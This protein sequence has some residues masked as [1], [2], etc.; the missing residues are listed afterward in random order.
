MLTCK[1]ALLCVDVFIVKDTWFIFL[2]LS[3]CFFLSET[4]ENSIHLFFS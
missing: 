1:F 3:S 4:I 2:L